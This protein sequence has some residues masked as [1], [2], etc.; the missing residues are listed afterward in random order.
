[1]LNASVYKPFFKV[2][3]ADGDTF[4]YD[5][6]YVNLS[7]NNSF[8][9]PAG[10]VFRLDGYFYSGGSRGNVN[11]EPRGS[12]DA[13]LSKS[14]LRKTLVLTLRGS[15]LFQWMNNDT[16]QEMNGLVIKRYTRGDSRSVSLTLTWRFNTQK[17]QYQGTGAGG[18]DLY[19]F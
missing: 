17:K 19:R 2:E 13:S 18:D 9:L 7:L 3:G 4:D 5:T 15:D 16:R 8:T 10:F 14:F 1:M 12:L 6:P 11:Y